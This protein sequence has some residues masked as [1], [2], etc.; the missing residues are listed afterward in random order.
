M[1]D[2]GAETGFAPIALTAAMAGRGGFQPRSFAGPAPE[3]VFEAEP[4]LPEAEPA[5]DPFARGL[6]EGQR[7]AEAAFVAER[8]RLLALNAATDALQDEPSEELAA[9]I[10]E[11][12]ERPVRQIVSTRPEE[13]R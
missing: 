2:R 10:A 12:V 13:R 4:A 3:T 1:S 9:L 11:T 7:L 5:E 8:H 6:A